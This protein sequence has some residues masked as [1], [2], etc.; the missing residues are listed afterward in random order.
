MKDMEHKKNF[1]TEYQ[2]IKTDGLEEIA[3]LYRIQ[4]ELIFQKISNTQPE[5]SPQ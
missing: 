2:K 1:F 4:R 5:N 3:L